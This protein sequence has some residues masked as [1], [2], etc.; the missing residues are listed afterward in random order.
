[1]FYSYLGNLSVDNPIGVLGDTS[2]NHISYIK[3]V[4]STDTLF[5][6]QSNYPFY[7]AVREENSKYYFVFPNDTN[8]VLYYDFNLNVGD[9]IHYSQ[10]EFIWVPTTLKVTAKDSIQIGNSYRKRI[11][12]V[13]NDGTG[14]WLSQVWI[15]G[16]G[17]NYGLRYVHNYIVDF[18]HAMSCFHQ[19]DT[20]V[21]LDSQFQACYRWTLVGIEENQLQ[22]LRAFPNPTSNAISFE[23]LSD[24]LVNTTLEIRNAQG[25]LYTKT[26]IN[27]AV[28]SIETSSFPD[29][30]YFY[31]I[32]LTSGKK[33][34]GKFMKL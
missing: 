16:I 24:E 20:L 9:T 10:N 12:L 30:I 18:E 26:A 11:R 5:N 3:V 28:F 2:I 1:M 7:C 25:K 13:N 29:G 32:Q 31:D 21:Y 15:E 22:P 34:H 33:L 8:E 23:V 4:Q 14:E 19:N 6:F 17:S 27:E